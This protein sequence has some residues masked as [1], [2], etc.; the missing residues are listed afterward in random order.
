QPLRRGACHGRADPLGDD[1]EARAAR[2]PLEKAGGG[3]QGVHPGPDARP[4][5]DLVE[6]VARSRIVEA[7]ARNPLIGKPLAKDAAESAR[8][9]LLTPPR[10][11]EQYGE[12]P[13]IALGGGEE[14]D[15][16]I[17]RNGLGGRILAGITAGIRFALY[18]F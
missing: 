1:D 18:V 9:Q 5:G 10:A 14:A 7:Q 6:R 12:R 17:E 15:R 2:S 4:K 16:S 8:A 13:G 3:E 11:G